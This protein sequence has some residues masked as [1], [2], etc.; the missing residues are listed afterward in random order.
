MDLKQ[1]SYFVTIV[2]QMSFSKAAQ[3]LHIS[4]P[5][6]SNAIKNLESELG[7]QLLERNTRNIGITEAGQILY[8]RAVHLLL[9]MDI[10]KKEMI[11]VKHI[12][13]GELQ[14]GMIESVKHWIPKVIL[15]YIQE[16]PDVRIKLTEVLSGADVKNSLRNYETHLI[17]TNQYIQEDDITTIP[18]Y[19]EKLVLLLHVNHPLV[20]HE[21]ITLKDLTEEAFIIS[22]EGFQT[23]QD[24]LNAFDMEG[25][26]PIIKYEIERFETALSLVRENIG[27]TLIP[28]NYLQGPQDLSIVKRP[29]D[30]AGV[31]RIVYLT[32]LKNRYVS[33]AIHAFINKTNAFFN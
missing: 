29:V 2:D 24:V 11:E 28:E 25:I 22:S 10:V 5:S 9:E 32:F 3:I 21:S 13:K 23:R 27:V 16:F 7:F 4:Q 26:K 14:I 20:K 8:T 33:P 17:I 30:S 18:L 19:H 31:N 15:Q 12:G 1:L 6:L